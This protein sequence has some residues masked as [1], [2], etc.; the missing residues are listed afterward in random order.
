MHDQKTKLSIMDG[1]IDRWGID[2]G[3]NGR[4]QY[5]NIKCTILY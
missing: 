3:I 2:G 5:L 4:L 1:R